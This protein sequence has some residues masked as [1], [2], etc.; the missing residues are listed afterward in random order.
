MFY[1]DNLQV[2][3]AERDVPILMPIC[4][5]GGVS[6][7][8]YRRENVRVDT[9]AFTPNGRSPIHV[10]VGPEKFFVPEGGVTY[11]FA[12]EIGI[13]DRRIIADLVQRSPSFEKKAIG[14]AQAQR[15]DLAQSP[16]AS[17]SGFS[18]N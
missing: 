12:R 7:T 3:V 6:K 18:N 16:K 5:P 8:L 17:I 13:G 9:E 1:K 15:V 4:G 14:F 2:A 11:G 10:H